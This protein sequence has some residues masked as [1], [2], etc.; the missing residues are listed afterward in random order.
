MTSYRTRTIARIGSAMVFLLN[1][2]S[3]IAFSVTKDHH[4]S[5]Y[6]AVHQWASEAGYT[7]IWQPQTRVGTVDFQALPREVPGDFGVAVNALVSG[8]A[9]G[10]IN[11][12]CVPPV[13]FRI[14]AIV[15]ERMRLV[16]V[17]GR[18]TG[19]RCDTPYP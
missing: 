19:R 15:D 18:A 11:L 3:V 5:A 1:A 2:P 8:A 7:V 14:E 12:Y 16:Y 9:Y 13:E 4:G 17:V 10:H 6:L